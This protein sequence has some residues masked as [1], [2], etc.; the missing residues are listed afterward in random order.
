MPTEMGDT[1]LQRENISDKLADAIGKKIIHNELKSGEIITETQISKEWN[2][3][4]SPVRDALHIL[5]TQRL[6]EKSSKGQYRVPVL[7]ADHVE[8][9]YDAIAMFYEYSFSRATKYVTDEDSAYLLSIVKK[10]EKSI[11]YG[12][13]DIYVQ[14]ISKF[15]HKVLKIARNPIIERSASELMP[16]AERIQFA[17][18]EIESSYIEKAFKYVWESYECISGKDLHN[19][20]KNFTLFSN[21]SRGILLNHLND[22]DMSRKQS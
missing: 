17:A 3:S 11:G 22:N 1:M 19:A 21:V 20:V 7:N 9:F 10:I 5:K 6:L 13:F 18:Y 16:T 14:G 2:I 8:N 4:R 12:D 15:A